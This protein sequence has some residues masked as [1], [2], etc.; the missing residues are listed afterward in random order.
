M[1][2]GENIDDSKKVSAVLVNNLHIDNQTEEL[3]QGINLAVRFQCPIVLIA[4]EFAV[5]SWERTK[6]LSIKTLFIRKPIYV[7]KLF[8][9]LYLFAINS[10]SAPIFAGAFRSETNISP[11]LGRE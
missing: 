11:S 1:E 7:P 4:D 9:D 10:D 3:S 6:K 8:N 5:S 2:I